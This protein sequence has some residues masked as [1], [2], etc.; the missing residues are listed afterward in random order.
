MEVIITIVSKLAY[1][2]L[3][4]RIQPTYIGV[5]PQLLSNYHGHP[6]KVKHGHMNTGKWRT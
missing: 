2:L 3:K 1:N 4:G 5:I 6:S